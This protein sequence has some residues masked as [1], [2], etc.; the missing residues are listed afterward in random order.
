MAMLFKP[1]LE[2]VSHFSKKLFSTKKKGLSLSFSLFK[3]AYL[4]F[5]KKVISTIEKKLFYIIKKGFLAEKKWSK[6]KKRNA[7]LHT[8]FFLHMQRIFFPW[9][10]LFLFFAHISIWS[11]PPTHLV[12]KYQ[13]LANP[14]HP[15]TYW[16]KPWMVLR[17]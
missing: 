2:S 7:F 8:A 16:H 4:N 17:L 5:L 12:R 11:P 3:K 14:T 9:I 15:S 6:E 13:H 1:F 10:F